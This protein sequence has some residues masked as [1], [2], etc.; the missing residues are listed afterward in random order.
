MGDDRRV[1]VRKQG[2]ALQEAEE[3]RH[4]LEVRWHIR[5]VAPE[6]HIVESDV[7]D[8][9]NLSPRAGEPARRAVR[10]CRARERSGSRHDQSGC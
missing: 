3:V 10:G 9:T 4:L 7:H 2:A 5:V 6:M 1:V 8:V